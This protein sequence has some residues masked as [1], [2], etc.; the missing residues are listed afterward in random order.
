MGVNIKVTDKIKLQPVQILAIG[1]AL[2]ILTG[3]VLLNLPIASQGGRRT[4]FIDCLFI[5][6][7]ATCVTGLVTVDTGTNWTYFGKTVIMCLIQIG[8]LGFMSFATLFAL[9]IGKR[10]T[11][12]ERL[13]MQESLNSFTLQGLVKMA[14]YVLIFTFSME[15]AGALLMSTQFVP[16][17]GIVKGIYYSLFH[18]VSAFCN[19]G[20]DII[21]DFKS[22]TPYYDNSVIILTVA[23]LIVSGGL[24]F[25]VWQEIY[26]YKGLKK[27]SLHSKLA[28]TTTLIL[29]FG[30]AVLMFL[31]EYNNPGTL[32]NMSLKGKILSSLFASVTPRTAGFNSISTADMS[33]AGRFLTIILMFVGGSPG[34]TA[35]G[36]KT[37]TAALLVMTVIS[38]IKGKD[39]T[40]VF[41]KRVAKDT[42]Y[43]ALVVSV[44]GLLLVVT[45]TMLL[46]VTEKGFSFEYILYETTSAF[47]TVG[48]T[49]GLTPKLT[50]IGKALLSFTMYAGRVGPL[51]LLLAIANRKGKSMIKYPEEKILVG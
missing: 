5:S 1:F 8:G 40:E 24:G 9:L 12:R 34:S 49:L 36:I 44:I 47:G 2:V 30:G 20:F 22:L 41:R 16:E 28:I 32:K 39:D 17:L 50:F 37:T 19:A 42:V 4:P 26:N 31:F 33:P 46:S 51:T 13:V 35:G 18:S 6:T 45:V 7:S 29:I 43:K 27:L 11:L 10:I 14:K 23:A 25:Y 48:L 38:S 3:A 15:G 21:G